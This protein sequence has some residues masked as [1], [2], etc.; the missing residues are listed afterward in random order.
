LALQEILK[1]FADAHPDAELVA[2]IEQDCWVWTDWAE[3]VLIAFAEDEKLGAFGA[4]HGWRDFAVDENTTVT[5]DGEPRGQMIPLKDNLAAWFTVLNQKRLKKGGLALGDLNWCADGF[6][7]GRDE[8][9]FW[10]GKGGDTGCRVSGQVRAT[11]LNVQLIPTVAWPGRGFGGL[12]KVPDAAG[13]RFN[14][15]WIVYHHFY[16]RHIGQHGELSV[17]HHRL[18]AEKV[19][20]HAVKFME[21]FMEK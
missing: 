18:T 20:E 15:R 21:M 17:G 11:G 6:V 7:V 12:A 13:A 10:V 16:G 8:Q 3:P 9:G 19:T 14:Q 4:H 2:V 5:G 1:E